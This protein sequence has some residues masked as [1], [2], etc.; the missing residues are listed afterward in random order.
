[1]VELDLTSVVDDEVV[2]EES[3]VLLVE[4]CGF[5]GV[6]VVDLFR[7]VDSTSSLKLELV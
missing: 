6:E 3:G 5:G 4:L 2:V 1:M 7:L